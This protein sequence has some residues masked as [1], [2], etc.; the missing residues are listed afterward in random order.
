VLCPVSERSTSRKIWFLN[1]FRR[2]LSGMDKRSILLV[3]DHR[4]LL[5]GVKNLLSSSNEF[6]VKGTA[7]SGKEALELIKANEYDIL[8][9][10]YE[11]P[12]LTGLELIKAAKTVLPEMK[13]VVLSMHDDPS[14]VK[15]ILRAGVNGYILKKDTH[16]TL[17]DALHKVVNGKRFLSDEISDL[18][19]Q[20]ADEPDERGVLTAR[21]VEILRLV[22]KEY[23]SRQIAEILFISERTVETHRKNI[24]K[25]TGASN[26]V[27]L[28]KYA[29]ANN[30]I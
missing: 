6:E 25:K 10:D 14:V 17:V 16:K 19:I 26:L 8:V 22:A 30:L 28:I 18:L 13:I 27:G 29:Y 15:E 2:I 20:M 5:D 4:I 23:S 11:L 24:L 9:T 3:D 12:G 1:P 21:E 7:A